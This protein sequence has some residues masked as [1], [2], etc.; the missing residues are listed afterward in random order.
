MDEQKNEER[1]D[2]TVLGTSDVAPMDF[3]G[4]SAG[5]DEVDQDCLVIPYLRIGQTSSDYMKR[6]AAK[7]IPGLQGGDFFFPLTGEV[8]GTDMNVVI[9]KFYRSYSVYESRDS[10]AKFLG[11]ITKEKYERDIEPTAVREKSYTLD[12]DGRRY[13]DNRN[14]VLV[15]YDHPERGA[16]LFSMSST[17]IKPSKN[18]LTQATTIKVKKADGSMQDAPIWS[19]VWNIKTDFFDNEAGGY[20][21]VAKVQR[22]GW[23]KKGPVAD[24]YKKLFDSLRDY[25]ASKIQAQDAEPETEP[26]AAEDQEPVRHVER[27]AQE[28]ATRTPAAEGEDELF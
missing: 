27:P 6:G 8:F 12:P 24:N 2:L 19:S 17:G 5:F 21:Q 7:F 1:K 3:D 28:Q 20:Y 15:D 11:V 14:F 25:D 4:Q 13:V 22:L 10:K 18:W 26:A 23:V 9:V 16:M